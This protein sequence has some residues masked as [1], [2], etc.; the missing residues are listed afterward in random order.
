MLCSAVTWAQASTAEAAAAAVEDGLIEGLCGVSRD[1]LD[2]YFLRVPERAQPF[3]IE[4]AVAILEDALKEGHLGAVGVA[5]D[6]SADAARKAFLSDS[7]F[8]VALCQS[9]NEAEGLAPLI[10]SRGGF[11]VT[12]SGLG[13]SRRP[14]LMA[15]KSESEVLE[16]TGQVVP[17]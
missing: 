10:E 12:R 15:V 3:Q 17:A 1:R 8:Q 11:V 4:G 13:T 14:S 6:G 2:L 7:I 5:V 16:A 9:V